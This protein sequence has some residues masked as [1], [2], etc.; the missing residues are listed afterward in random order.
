[1][2]EKITCYG[3]IELTD[4]IQN[5]SSISHFP[6]ILIAGPCGV[7]KTTVSRILAEKLNFSFIDHDEMKEKTSQSPFPC[8]VSK[9]DLDVC[10]SKSLE[11]TGNP[12]AFIFAVGGD[13]VFHV[14]IDNKDRLMQ[15]LFVKEKFCLTIL[16]M[17][18][19][20]SVLESRFHKVSGR[21][22]FSAVWDNWQNIERQYWE[23]SADIIIDT[24]NL[25]I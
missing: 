20:R 18:A 1:M 9:L 10:L 15:L 12:D 3:I 25:V 6:K 13:S 11:L 14:N 16:L 4:I 23:K 2:P 21:S 22:G 17:V 24:S 5:Y 19:E 7:G 8:S